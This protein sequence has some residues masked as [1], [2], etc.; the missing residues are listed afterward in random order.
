MHSAA[1]WF[2]IYIA[3]GKYI[4][5]F[6]IR[7]RNADPMR[8]QVTQPSTFKSDGKSRKKRLET[9]AHHTQE[10]DRRIH[11]EHSLRN[12]VQHFPQISPCPISTN[13]YAP[14]ADDGAPEPPCRS[15]WLPTLPAPVPV[16]R[17]PPRV[18]ATEGV[19]QL[20]PK[21]DAK[22]SPPERGASL[23]KSERT[24]QRNES[25]SLLD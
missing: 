19:A 1:R 6:H 5:C 24:I 21:I 2:I 20:E 10:S 14:R 8:H 17:P 4:G 15:K 22:S 12:S 7:R 9:I 25:K 3:T 23:W 18:E 13:L 11:D 16:P